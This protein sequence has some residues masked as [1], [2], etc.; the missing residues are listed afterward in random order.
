[1]GLGSPVLGLGPPVLGGGRCWSLLYLFWVHP[2]WG[3]LALV[4]I[5]AP[6]FE[7]SVAIRL[8][9]SKRN[10][11]NGAGFTRVGA[12]STRVGRR[13]LLIVAVSLIRATWTEVRRVRSAPVG[14]DVVF[15]FRVF[16][17]LVVRSFRGCARCF[18]PPEVP[19]GPTGGRDRRA[20]RVL[21]LS[22]LFLWLGPAEVSS[23]STT[24][25]YHISPGSRLLT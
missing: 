20:F 21:R 4:A 17:G 12:G 24:A 16:A 3:P 1:M 7:C 22:L 8:I 2:C 25:L 14:T 15:F 18:G 23:G 5:K 19:S 10:L 11:V 6:V 9:I 13:A